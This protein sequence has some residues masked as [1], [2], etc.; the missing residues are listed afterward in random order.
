MRPS[1]I[2]WAGKFRDINKEGKEKTM[3]SMFTR[4]HCLATR[5]NKQTL[6]GN[7]TNTIHLKETIWEQCV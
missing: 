5:M 1:E 3:Q 7:N 4:Q 6:D 2:T